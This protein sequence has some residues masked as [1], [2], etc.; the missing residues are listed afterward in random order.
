VSINR[1]VS[2]LALRFRSLARRDD[3]EHDLDDELRYHVERQIEEN[4]RSGMSAAAARTAAL[5]AF[6]GVEYQKE[7]ARDR[8]GTRWL[9]DLYSDVRFSLRSLRRT[10]AFTITVIIT[11]ALG[12]GVNTAMFTVLRGAL[13][14]ELPNRNADRILVLRQSTA[15]PQPTNL[16][17]SVPEVGDFRAASHTVAE[18]AEYSWSATS[19]LPFT[20]AIGNELPMRPSVAIVSGN[21]FRVM[22]LD[23]ELGRL[24]GPGD[25]GPSAPAVAVLSH[26]F[27]VSHFAA[28][29]GVIGRTVRVNDMPVTL[30]GVA[31]PAAPYPERTDVFANTSSSTHHMDA[32]MTTSRTHRM[33]QV[34]A[35]LAPGATLESAQRELSGIAANAHR[36]NPEAYSSRVRY[37]ISV[38]RVRDAVNERAARTLWL[39]MGAAV[40][41]LIIA[42]ANV[43][44]L[45]LIRSVSRERELQVRLALGAGKARLRR[46]LIV[47]NLVLTLTGAGLAVAIA[48]GGTE[49]L[50]SFAARLSTRAT[51]VHVDGMVL[52]VCLG[53]SILAALVLSFIPPLRDGNPGRSLI[54]PSRRATMTRARQR[55][56]RGLVIAQVA[57]CV[58]LLAGAGLMARTLRGLAAI[59]SGV[60]ADHVLAMDIP[61]PGDFV[62][63][64]GRRAENLVRYERIRDN[65]ASVPGVARVA[66]TSAQPL[67]SSATDIAILVEGHK[68]PANTPTPRGAYKAV[69]P[70]YFGIVGVPLL[71]GR[72]FV[73]TDRVGSER[74]AI[75]SKG[76]AQQLFG[77]T[78][79]IGQRVGMGD[80][81]FNRGPVNWLTVVG[82]VGDTRDRGLDGGLTAT[83]YR[84]FAQDLIITPSLVARTASNPIALQPDIVRAIRDVEP[85]QVIERA[86]TIDQIRDESTA[87]RRVIGIFIA[88]FGALAF[89]LAMV[90]VGGLLAFSVST[91]T[92]EF[93]IR[94]SLGADARRV[95]AMILAE[96]GA[97]LLAGILAGVVAATVSTRLLRA[98][99]FGISPNDP[100]TLSA[101]AI[102][103]VGVGLAACWLPAARAARVQPAIALRA[104]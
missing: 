94:M 33:S 92:S 49:V 38:R 10:P 31:L 25:D 57:L 14:R 56:Q 98:L 59:D 1:L 16:G 36:A 40:L 3:V 95:R 75:L 84:P 69:D 54:S 61:L 7:E 50:I 83:I 81:P 13:L 37:E 15:G 90:G 96:G 63:E 101:V 43:S 30:V 5:R 72:D 4:V 102:A 24:I 23:A 47:E 87:P 52:A 21:Y 82:V 17:F 91:R 42:C 60:R 85:A 89:V 45:T 48:L 28:D 26:E 68:L 18:F 32:M 93:G 65:V 64:V 20:L 71:S 19:A 11:L 100:V 67:H 97:L 27:W 35:R 44:N 29:S 104:E 66:L 6:G 77:T 73:T 34:F 39:L 51:E 8:R 76:L 80:G 58:V 12:I 86:M 99:L 78:N 79:P 2:I 70:G 41:V 9:E 103:L 22:G 74:V 46:L 88:S 62:R 53:T 55:F